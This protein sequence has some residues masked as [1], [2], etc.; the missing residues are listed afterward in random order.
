MRIEWNLR[1]FINNI[2]LFNNKAD[3]CTSKKKDKMAK[4]N[5]DYVLQ[6]D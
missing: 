1:N 4:M 3:Y 2:K 6:V 5:I